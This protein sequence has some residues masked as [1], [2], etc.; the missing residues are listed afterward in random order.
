MAHLRLTLGRSE[1]RKLITGQELELSVVDKD[2]GLP[3][4]ICLEDIG[5]DVMAH[6]IG[7]VAKDAIRKMGEGEAHKGT[8][9]HPA[10]Q[11]SEDGVKTPPN[12]KPP[13]KD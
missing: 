2:K 3:V 12:Y 9:P 6:D 7:Q 4:S 8:S 13:T 11:P 10:I 1:W 5:L